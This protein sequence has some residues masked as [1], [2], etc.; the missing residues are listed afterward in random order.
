MS[1][2]HRKNKKSFFGRPVWRNSTKTIEVTPQRYYQP[3]S[4]QDV[5][6]MVQ[7]GI[8]T[9]TPV[10]AVGSGHSF[11]SAPKAEGILID[12]DK[13][14][15]LDVYEFANKTAIILRSREG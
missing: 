13:L 10:R 5:V 6:E 15:K 4:I 14:N 8:D 1:S 9:N 7:E 11:S 12:T 2:K 3:E